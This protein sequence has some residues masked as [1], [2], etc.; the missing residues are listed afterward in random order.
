MIYILDTNVISAAR[1]PD[2]HDRLARWLYAQPEDQLFLSV[3]SIGEIARGIRQQQT[4]NPEF[5]QDLNVW[6]DRT[7]AVFQD[8]VL[9]FTARDARIWGRL[10]A[11]IGHPGA[12]LM[13]AASAL[14]HKATVVTRNIAD[15]R[16][17]KVRLLNPF[18]D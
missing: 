11:E 9:P 14:A 13:I 3:I 12:D 18:E 15:F 8:R 5:A 4:R 17:T 2:R 7:E 10:S 1:R 6:L 16:P